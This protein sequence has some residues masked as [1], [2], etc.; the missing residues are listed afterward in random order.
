[1]VLGE[2]FASTLAAARTGAEWAWTALYR[3]LAPIVFGYLR[4][5]GASEP[6]DVLAEVF[7]QVVRNLGD[8]DGDEGQFRTWVFT[9]AH[10]RAVDEYRARS[11]RPVDPVAP[12]TLLDQQEFIDVEAQA[13]ARTELDRALRLMRKLSPDRRS[14]LLLR[15]VGALS[16]DEIA[17]VLDKRPGA[18]KVQLR[19]ALAA[20]NREISKE[21]VPS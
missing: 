15:L 14:V 13:I 17:S 6:E 11:V 2:S 4:G 12:D 16:I 19:R 3:D 18:V 10:R 9:I 21:G 1:V 8:F 20:L 5:R 7:L